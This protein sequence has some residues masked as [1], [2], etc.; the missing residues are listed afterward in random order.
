MSRRVSY[1]NEEGFGTSNKGNR[2]SI[3]GDKEAIRQ[4]KAEFSRT[5]G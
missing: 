1:R 4:E 3:E 2:R 5:K